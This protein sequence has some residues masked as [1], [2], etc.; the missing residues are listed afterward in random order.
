MMIP[1]KMAR[2]RAVLF[3]GSNSIS[4]K[5]A[6]LILD[7]DGE[8]LLIKVR[9]TGKE[10]MLP[11]DAVEHMEPLHPLE[12]VFEDEAAFVEAATPAP[13]PPAPPKPP[14]ANPVAVAPEG[15]SADEVRMVKIDGKIV[16]RKGPPRADEV[17]ALDRAK[18]ERITFL[19][20]L[21][22]EEL[23]S[24]Q[25]EMIDMHDLDEATRPTP[26]PTPKK[27]STIAEMLAST[28]ATDA[29]DEE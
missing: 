13:V 1:L 24:A 9:A 27:P 4:A 18:K 28:K 14:H 7:T 8:L 23:T 17:L 29:Q 21:P 3:G 25:R 11:L 26:A 10:Y 6:Q 12:G 5:A 22:A 19:K 16:E 2:T 15:P 20:T